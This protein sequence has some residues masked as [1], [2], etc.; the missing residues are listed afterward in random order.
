MYE[1]IFYGVSGRGATSVWYEGS[2]KQTFEWQEGSVFSI[3]LN[4]WHELYNA[5]GEETA[6][7]YACITAP[8]VF[9]M[10][11]NADFIFGSEATVLHRF[12][13]YAEPYVRG[14]SVRRADRRPSPG[15]S[16]ICSAAPRAT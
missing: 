13:P 5:S 12:M 15:G 11:G 1:E 14:K 9:N 8:M 4:A 6:R 3:P 2:P 16:G 10:C 7:L